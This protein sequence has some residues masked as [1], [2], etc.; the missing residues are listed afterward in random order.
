MSSVKKDSAI[1][2]D[3]TVTMSGKDQAVADTT[4]QAKTDGAELKDELRDCF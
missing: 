3:P 4:D 2:Q 1:K